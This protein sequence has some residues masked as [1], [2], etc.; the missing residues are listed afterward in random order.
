MNPRLLSYPKRL[1]TPQRWKPLT[2]G[3]QAGGLAFLLRPLPSASG[4]SGW[5]TPL[6]G[7]NAPVLC[8]GETSW[9][10]RPRAVHGGSEHWVLNHTLKWHR[11]AEGRASHSLPP[12]KTAVWRGRFPRKHSDGAG[13]CARPASLRPSRAC[14]SAESCCPCPRCPAAALTLRGDATEQTSLRSAAPFPLGWEEG[15]GT[16]PPAPVC[17]HCP[18][19]L[20]LH[21]PRRKCGEEG[22]RDALDRCPRTSDS[23]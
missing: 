20:H 19:P 2:R 8:P 6:E 15:T 9:P 16:P 18:P 22:G 13:L 1:G 17:V 14:G 7:G 23:A 5:D 4:Q 3:P 11:K 21:P 10:P 12:W